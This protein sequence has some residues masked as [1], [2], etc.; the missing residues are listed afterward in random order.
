MKS[1]FLKLFFL[2]CLIIVVFMGIKTIRESTPEN[3][4]EV[5]ITPENF[6]VMTYNMNNGMGLDG[7]LELDRIIKIM[8]K[9]NPDLVCLNEV[10][11]LTERS[12]FIDQAR[13]IS[14]NLG[15]E[16]T[17]AKNIEFEKG[18]SGNAV[19]SRFPIK[20][21][22]NKQYISSDVNI[23][24]GVLH[25]IVTMGNEDIHL[26][27]TQF[28]SDTLK[29]KLETKQLLDIILD[30]GIEKPALIAGD[31]AVDF[32]DR[33]L[34]ELLYY[35]QDTG[36]MVETIKATWPSNN[37]KKRVDYILANHYLEPLIARTVNSGLSVI[38]SDHLPFL[39]RFKIRQ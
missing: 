27:A 20:F 4:D 28:H 37:P 30:W 19:L 16:F 5:K 38:A 26:Y 36:G 6:K 22:E 9:E 29:S 21:A 10:D 24:S 12:E 34:G 31:F 25:V 35:F 13:I 3:D 8:R 7:K 11:Y 1:F 23:G 33:P 39:V 15:M 14:A 2:L 32:A 18:G 17:F